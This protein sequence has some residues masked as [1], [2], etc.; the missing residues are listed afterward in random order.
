MRYTRALIPTLKEA[1]SEASSVSHV[2]LLRAGYARRVS[3]GTYAFLPLGLRV[4]R[5]LERLL[6]S[7]LEGAGALE[8]LLPAQL[9]AERPSG[10]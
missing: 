2:L 9:P 3:G 4:L 7:E 8:L 1:P 10:I 5:K 6:R